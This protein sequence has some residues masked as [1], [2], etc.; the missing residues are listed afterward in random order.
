[1]Q[2]LGLLIGLAVVLVAVVLALLVGRRLRRTGRRLSPL[3]RVLVL[4]G[5]LLLGVVTVMAWYALD[6]LEWVAREAAKGRDDLG[7]A[8][9]SSV[10][11]LL[12]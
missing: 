3:G 9:A 7:I 12:A 10:D 11:D 5:I 2:P 4:T 1:M 6:A 8:T